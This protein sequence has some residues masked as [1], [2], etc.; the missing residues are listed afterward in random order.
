[1]F[2][3]RLAAVWQVRKF[4]H[5][6]VT[7]LGLVVGLMGLTH[8]TSFIVSMLILFIAGARCVWNVG[9]N[10]CVGSTL[11]AISI[12]LLISLFYFYPIWI[13][14]Q[15][16]GG[17]INRPGY[18][19]LPTSLV[20]YGP[21]PL[22]ALFAIIRMPQGRMRLWTVIVFTLT[23]STW[24]LLIS[25]Q[26]PLADLKEILPIRP[27]RFGIYLS[28]GLF[29]L[30]ALGVFAIER[31]QK[32]A[33]IAVVLITLAAG[34]LAD[35]SYTEHLSE[36]RKLS[37]LEAVIEKQRGKL[38]IQLGGLERVRVLLSKPGTAVVLCPPKLC[39]LLAYR[40]GV[41]V[42]YVG[43]PNNKWRHFFKKTIDQDRRL[44]L[45]NQFYS[46][47][48]SGAVDEE[49]LKTFHSTAFVTT[50]GNITVGKKYTR[51]ELG[52]FLDKTWFLYES[53]S[54]SHARTPRGINV[55][56]DR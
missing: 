18:D 4:K 20:L 45:V 11:A 28:L 35:I 16:F 38:P 15:E 41:D 47:L 6:D 37:N 2:A 46:R 50:I 17:L 49:V 32:R 36:R 44:K 30:S 9:I 54:A 14:A 26:S 29:W 7:I 52:V 8:P 53:D 34:V 48:E 27:H 12:A 56:M 31:I 23:A 33:A 55:G 1:M 21:L 22:L 42:P 13:Y 39:Y 3:V 51:H 25:P 43:R 19:M 10:R 5:S 40:N 24:M